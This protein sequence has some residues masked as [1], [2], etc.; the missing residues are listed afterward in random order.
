M[1]SPKF[2]SSSNNLLFNNSLEI[3]AMAYVFFLHKK[4]P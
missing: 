2:L 3:E 4:G 1:M